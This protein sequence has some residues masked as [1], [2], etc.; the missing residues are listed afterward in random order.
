MTPRDRRALLVGAA[1]IVGGVLVFRFVPWAVR[2]VAG[3]RV[4]VEQQTQLASEASAVLAV[5]PAMRDS[6]G[7]VLGGIIAL[8]P[9]LVDGHTTAEAQASLSGLVSLAANRHALRVVRL[10]PLTDSSV[11]VFNRV[12]VHAELEGDIAGFAG[13][14]KTVEAGEPLLSIGTLAVTAPDPRSNGK[15]PELLHLELDVTGYFL[16]RGSQ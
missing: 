15:A 14:L 16:P 3:L 6:L 2:G 8:A 4:R 9:V 7:R 11:G 12:T 10:D 5:A 13:L 1:A